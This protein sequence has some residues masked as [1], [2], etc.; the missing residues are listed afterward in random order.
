L[1]VSAISS[2]DTA[3]LVERG[4]LGLTLDIDHWL[5]LLEAS[6]LTPPIASSSPRPES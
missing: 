5:A 1:R 3:T 4:R 6:M 2:W